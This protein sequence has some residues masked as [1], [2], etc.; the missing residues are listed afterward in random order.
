MQRAK[1]ESWGVW[2]EAWFAPCGCKAHGS[3]P[4][5][6]YTLHALSDQRGR[7]CMYIGECRDC[8]ATWI[9]HDTALE[10]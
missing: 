8:G 2:A 3:A 9:D 5:I 6:I 10:P 7:L 1:L 4:I